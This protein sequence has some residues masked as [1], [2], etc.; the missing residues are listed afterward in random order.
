MLYDSRKEATTLSANLQLRTY[1]GKRIDPFN[2][3]LDDIAIEDIAHHLSNICRFNG[4]CS[5][6]YSVAEHSFHVSYRIS[7]QS[8]K[9]T[10]LW[11]LLHDAAEA[12]LGDL[13]DP[14]KQLEECGRFRK[15]E[16]EILWLVAHK[17]G[18]PLPI[19]DAVW[20]EDK[21]I[22]Q[23]EFKLFFDDFKLPKTML[24]LDAEQQFLKRFREL[25][26]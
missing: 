22:L 3:T 16:E 7:A 18:L 8:R 2:M 17:Y 25:S 20:V 1:S 14:F 5:T 24:P 13:L 12:Y 4:A 26:T 11:G 9:P 15:A 23:L 10:K 6:F 19:P 21:A